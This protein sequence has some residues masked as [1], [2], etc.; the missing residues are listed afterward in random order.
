MDIL[1]SINCT[2][3]NHEKYIAQALDSFLM[4]ETNFAWE[5]LVHDD[6]STD[7]TA[8]IIKSYAE[9]YPDIIRPMFQN[10][11]Q[12]SLGIKVNTTYNIPRSRGK[13]I[14]WCDG[15]DYWTDPFKLQKQAD[16]M[17]NNPV[18]SLCLTRSGL[19]RED[20]QRPA[21]FIRPYNESRIIPREDIILRKGISHISSLFFRKDCLKEPPAF[22]LDGPMGDYFLIIFLALKGDAYYI[23]EHMSDYRINVPNSWMQLNFKGSNDQ[24]IWLNKEILKKLQNLN[25]YTDFRYADIIRPW[26]AECEQAIIFAQGNLS[27]LRDNKYIGKDPGNILPLAAKFYLYKYWPELYFQF[28]RINRNLKKLF[29]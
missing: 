26:Q 13:Y 5:I 28:R 24:R 21:G 10:E 17:E 8:P 27:G 3:Y 20:Q 25:I 1:V 12:H 9:R 14:A 18:C 15:D 22:Y 11:N 23:D 29:N 16:Y 6:A 4:Q 2:T 7:G 19:F